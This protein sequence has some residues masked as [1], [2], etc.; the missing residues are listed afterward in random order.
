MKIPPNEL[1]FFM[2]AGAGIAA[3]VAFF[4][5]IFTKISLH[6]LGAGGLVGLTLAMVR[7]STYDLRIIL[8]VILIITGLTGSARLV[9]KAHTPTQ[10]FLGYFAGFLGQFLAFTVVPKYL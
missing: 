4:V 6:S 5:N 9:L 8:V 7:Y 3:F 2:L 10:V 1:I